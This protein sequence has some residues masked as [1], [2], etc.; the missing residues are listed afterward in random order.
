MVSPSQDTPTLDTLRSRSTEQ[1][2]IHQ[3]Q[4]ELLTLIR[5]TPDEAID[6]WQQASISLGN[7]SST[8]ETEISR[9]LW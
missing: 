9:F 5:V 2:V 6:S 7:W 1:D 8:L 3:I 4:S